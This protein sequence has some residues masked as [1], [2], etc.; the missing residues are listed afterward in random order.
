M[1]TAARSCR[2]NDSSA[3]AGASSA[4]ICAADPGGADDADGPVLVALL[5]EEHRAEQARHPRRQLDERLAGA[6]DDVADLHEDGAEALPRVDA[7]EPDAQEARLHRLAGVGGVLDLVVDERGGERDQL[8]AAVHDDRHGALGALDRGA[9]GAA[10]VG[11]E[12]RAV[13]RDDPV[14]RL[15]ARRGGGRLRRARGAGVGGGRDAGTTHAL[16]VPMVVLLAGTPMPISTIAKSTTARM[17]FMNGPAN[18]TTIRFQGARIQ[19]WRSW[20]S[21]RTSIADCCRASSIRPWNGPV[22]RSRPASRPWRAGSCR[23]C[24]CSRRAGWP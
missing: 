21:G 18:I 20:S 22:R 5:A 23:S 9:Q 19:N 4:R 8:A 1:F 17:R 14:A 6:P 13:E 3:A 10:V 24:G 12:G 2:K 7:D 15:E 11:V 16:T